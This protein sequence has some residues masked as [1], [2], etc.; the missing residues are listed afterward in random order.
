LR[1]SVANTG[2]HST[3]YDHLRG[4]GYSAFWECNY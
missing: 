4:G 2:K 1:R 3:I